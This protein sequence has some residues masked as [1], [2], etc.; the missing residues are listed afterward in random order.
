M[1][2]PLHTTDNLLLNRD[3]GFQLNEAW[4]PIIHRLRGKE[5]RDDS[6]T[7]VQTRLQGQAIRDTFGGGTAT[8]PT[9]S[10]ATDQRSHCWPWLLGGYINGTFAA[11]EHF[12]VEDDGGDSR[13]NVVVNQSPGKPFLMRFTGKAFDHYI[14][15]HKIS[16][17]RHKSRNCYATS[18]YL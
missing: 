11:A 14:I 6:R 10:P 3:A 8:T 4:A 2:D 9:M 16:S 1:Y 18:A 5:H 13:R 17:I 12:S 7:A 15:I